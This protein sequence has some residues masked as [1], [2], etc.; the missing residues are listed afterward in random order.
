MKL[1]LFYIHFLVIF[2][3]FNYVP[4]ITI[5]IVCII[6]GTVYV[7][8]SDVLSTAPNVLYIANYSNFVFFRAPM[9][10]KFLVQYVEIIRLKFIL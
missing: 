5:F 6:E 8:S 1:P 10:I 3:Y 7:L 2:H 9:K 4:I